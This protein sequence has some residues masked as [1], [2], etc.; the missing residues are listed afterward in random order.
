[1]ASFISDEEVERSLHWLADNASKAA[2][3]RAD[4]LY[5]EAFSKVLI[6]QIMKEHATLPV[7]AQ[8]REAYADPRYEMHLKGL[9]EAIHND[10]QIQWRKA[11]HEAKLESWRTMSATERAMK[12]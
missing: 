4:R 2:Q 8:E 6:A 7:S 5:L 12:L 9:K 11:A 3:C 1:M 10:V